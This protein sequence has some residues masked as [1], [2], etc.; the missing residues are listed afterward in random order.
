MCSKLNV[1]NQLKN[2]LDVKACQKKAT[3][4]YNLLIKWLTLFFFYV[5]EEKKYLL[6]NVYIKI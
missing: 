4:S 3:W 5:F 1:L 6:G 2:I